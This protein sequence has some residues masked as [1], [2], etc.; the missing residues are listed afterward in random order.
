MICIKT[1]TLKA[2]VLTAGIALAWM[3]E[4]GVIA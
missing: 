3:I 4:T 2:I 1:Q